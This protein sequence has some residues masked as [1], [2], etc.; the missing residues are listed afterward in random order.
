MSSRHGRR[1]EAIPNRFPAAQ[2]PPIWRD[3]RVLRWIFQLGVFCIVAAV[4]GWLYSNYRT[5]VARTNIP[6]DFKFLDRPS[7]FEIP[8]NRCRRRPRFATRSSRA[9]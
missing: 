9:S 4:L 5:N 7:N 8:G 2:R 1:A 6:T 3:V